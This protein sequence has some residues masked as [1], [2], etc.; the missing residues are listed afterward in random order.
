[1]RSSQLEVEAR[2]GHAT[3]LGIPGRQRR[4]ICD[5]PPFARAHRAGCRRQRARARW[6][7]SNGRFAKGN[8]GASARAAAW[9]TDFLDSRQESLILVVKHIMDT[10]EPGDGFRV[11]IEPVGLTRD[12]VE[13]FRITCAIPCIAPPA[14]LCDWFEQHPDGYDYFCAGY[15]QMLTSPSLPWLKELARAACQDNY[16]LLHQGDSPAENSATALCEFLS[17]L[18]A[19]FHPSL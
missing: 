6:R 14:A 18:Q 8:R 9:A 4:E 10:V 15:H 12:F 2:Y 3:H 1:M 19:Y 5:D 17:N 11:W 16:T 13:W 7:R